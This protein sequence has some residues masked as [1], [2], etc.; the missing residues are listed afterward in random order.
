MEDQNRTPQVQCEQCG[1]LHGAQCFAPFLTPT[2]SGGDL[3]GNFV[4]HECGAK[5]TVAF[6]VEPFMEWWNAERTA[7]VQY[8]I[9]RTLYEEQVRKSQLGRDVAAFRRALENIETVS[10]LE[11]AWK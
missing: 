5:Y 2:P 11:V 3:M 7:N 8:E 6:K 1:I 4:C 9:Q 10:D